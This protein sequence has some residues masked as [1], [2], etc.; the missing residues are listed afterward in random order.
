MRINS[1]FCT[2]PR[3]AV[4]AIFCVLALS[5][6]A[7]P[8]GGTVTQGAASFNSHGSQFT[9]H[10]TTPFAHIN[11][12]SF[13]IGLGE[14]TSIV[15][16]SST[17]LLWNQINSGNP[18]QILGNINANGYVLLQNPSGFYI[19][20][21]ASVTAHGVIFTTAQ[22]APPDVATGGAWSFNAPPPTAK[23]INYGSLD[24]GGG[25][26]FLI[27]SDIENHGT[28][29]DNG[30]N[31]GLYAGKQVLLSTSPDGRGLSA[32][33]TL[34]QGSVDNSGRLIADGGSIAMRAQVV[35]QGGLVQANSVRKVN[36]TIELY[37]SD[38]VN[39]SGTSVISAQG[40]A[41]GVSPAGNITIKSG[42]SYSDQAGSVIN[43]SGGTQGGNG[44]QVEISAPQISAI[45]S[46]INGH[47]AK[48]YTAGGLFIDPDNILLTDYG[49]SAPANGTVN[50]SDPN[51]PGSDTLTL[52]VST[53]N[54]LIQNNNLS[55]ISLAANYNIEVGTLWS[56]PDASIASSITLNAGRNTT[57]DD[58]SGIQAGRNWSLT[59]NA[60]KELTS[61]ANR[62]SG[63]DGIYLQGSG[64]IQTQNGDIN[65]TA[66]NEVMVDT[67][68]S[69]SS[70][71]GNGITTRAGG[72]INVT[73]N[74][75]DVNTGG[76]P[77]GYVFNQRAAPY[78]K[79]SS[80]LG[81]ISTAN[82]GNVTITAGGNVT[83][84]LPLNNDNSEAGAGA[85][86]AAPGD[87]T[88]TAGGSV[89]GHYVVANGTGTITAENGNCG[90]P[91]T[92]Q[93]FAL[94]LISGSWSVNAPNGSIYLQ[95]V[96]NP[97][98]VFNNKGNATSNPGFH[99][100]N[101]SADAS[102]TLNAADS[103]EITGLGI[104]RTSD[105]VP[106]LFPP[107]LEVNA[108]AGGFV[109]DTSV[110]LFPSPLQELNI[111]TTD[112]G[113]LV[114]TPDATGLYPTLS[115]SDSASRQ[116]TSSFSFSTAD[117]ASTPPE[118]KNAAPV[119]ISVGGSIDTLNL[120][121]DKQTQINVAGDLIN[122]SFVGE[123]L[124]K[125]DVT[126]ITVGGQIFN[127]PYYSFANLTQP[128]TPANPL[129]P[130][131][132][133]IFA[134]LVN[135]SLIQSTFVPANLNAS[136]L[137]SQAALMALFQVSPGSNPNPGFVYNPGS[138]QLGFGGQMSSATL[139]AMTGTLEAITYGADGLPEVANGHFVTHP[140]S[141]VPN[142]VIEQL[143]QESLA[144]PKTPL[145]GFQ[146]GG[147][148]Q[149]N[150]TAGS[151]NLGSSQGIESWGYGGNYN[152]LLPYTASG[153]AVTVTLSGNL[154]MVTS[155]I[156]S[157]DGGNVTV[158]ST[159][160]Q[161]D[162]GSQELFGTSPLAFG[163]YT[164][165]HSDVTVIAD[166][167][168]N[169]N[170]S[171]IAAYNG[172]NIL[173]VESLEG[174]VNCGSGGNIYVNVPLV[175]TQFAGY[176]EEDPIYG[177]GVV[178]VSLP[179]D[180]QTP[181]GNPLPGN[182]TIKTPR[183][184]IISEQAGILQLALDG[185]IAGGPSVTLTAGTPASGNS[186]AI[187]GNIDLGDSG[188]IGGTVNLTAQ[189]NINGLVISRQN[190]TIN[191][192]QN[193]SGT[194]LSAGNANVSAGGTISGT[195]IGISGVSASAGSITASLLSQ[196]VSV[197]G[198]QAT[199]TLGTA[200][201][202]TAASQSAAQQSTTEAKQQIASNDNL[203]NDDDKKKK[204]RPLLQR[205]KRV[206]VILPNS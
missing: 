15:Q 124:H 55:T 87:V 3:L 119:E 14:T 200:A 63:M 16:P 11:W 136:D 31:I 146:I 112:G 104:P 78:Y 156:A 203:N 96:R 58:Q 115:M 76:S 144:V 77:E 36:G 4:Q 67:G 34:P 23:I 2:N 181:G 65:L 123:N 167:D 114:G 205:V 54:D 190:S 135:P 155:R 83:S 28:I 107:S 174:N 186:P 98:G 70:V 88:I 93:G 117:H 109:L 108:G 176:T 185:S 132:D 60:G 140:V 1:L 81:G 73:A 172:G 40:D 71:D 121:T 170:G 159:G 7:N 21:Q 37:A 131:W 145:N 127:Q 197:G 74:F 64:I 8:Q 72:S 12:Q 79:V 105:P 94:S 168:L 154:D 44:G 192:A 101:Y 173:L 85:Y 51:D 157:F 147:P 42:G 5:A 100:F 111:T 22:A 50:A 177:S 9:I 52:D 150:I 194:L 82:G 59:M 91:L 102:V 180:L 139:T 49:D 126:S 116:W 26:A 95:E 90:A 153:A 187:P 151:M 25:P 133:S 92:S 175:S 118:L 129:S 27:A 97:A 68:S 184:N 32:E 41:Q 125:G 35:N 103:V 19:G 24:I 45:Q 89:F 53:F 69:G 75:G 152:S 182:I 18:S 206:T 43:V 161:M 29:S 113:N 188:L 160:G 193:F 171:R 162:L 201:T 17:S 169:I 62:Q 163:I 149:F 106:I 148:G 47:A 198:G 120:F 202:A 10:Q 80:T 164:S 128:I 179:K 199:S 66:G 141:F 204:K 134:I 137:Q 99:R 195:I 142:S 13:N 20:G 166:K 56:V 57:I 122:S 6:R 165:G 46:T 48:G 158:T 130:T 86:G 84:Y 183:G 33:V 138:R 191:A 189:G 143:Y 30:G 39:L 38:A 196:N 110:T 178:A 61:A